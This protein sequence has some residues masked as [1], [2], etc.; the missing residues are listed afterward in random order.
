MFRLTGS[1]C[2]FGNIGVTWQNLGTEFTKRAH[3]FWIPWSFKIRLLGKPQNIT[4]QITIIL[5]SAFLTFEIELA[6][7]QV[8]FVSLANK[9]LFR[10]IKIHTWQWGLGE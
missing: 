3:A 6:W 1:Q 2:K 5:V 9:P 10:Y 7:Y 4:Y 8:V